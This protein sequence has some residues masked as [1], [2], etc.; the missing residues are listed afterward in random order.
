MTIFVEMSIDLHIF[1]P[2][3][4]CFWPNKDK[5]GRNWK[6]EINRPKS[7]IDRPKNGVLGE[8]YEKYSKKLVFFGIKHRLYHNL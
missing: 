6:V 3:L 4:H 8:F 5:R 2:Q 7:C 1:T